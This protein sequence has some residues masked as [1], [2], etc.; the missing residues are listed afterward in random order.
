MTKKK[1]AETVGKKVTK[2]T[3]PDAGAEAATLAKNTPNALIASTPTSSAGTT[4]LKKTGKT[5]DTVLMAEGGTIPNAANFVGPPTADLKEKFS[6]QKIPLQTNFSDLIDVADCGRKAVGLSPGQLGGTGLG[7]Q[8]DAES[9]LAVIAG[10]GINVD[11][12]GV[13]V[14][15]PTILPSGMIMMFH[16]ANI[17]QGW[18]LC[19][20]ANGTPDLRDRFI[21]GGTIADSGSSNSKVTGAVTAK[22]FLANTSSVTP[23]VIVNIHD[24]VLNEEQ[25]PSH[26]HLGGIQLK[27]DGSPPDVTHYSYKVENNDRVKGTIDTDNVDWNRD[28]S[29][30]AWTSN[31]GGN[32]GHNHTNDA[33]QTPHNHSI[34]VVPPYCILAFIMKV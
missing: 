20:G 29:R 16:G 34:N 31:V 24:R 8:L 28:R 10:P 27:E 26:K 25:L 12:A 9:R 6:A 21:L 11:S 33:S 4:R 15:I 3:L 14:D 13:S 2:K 30:L 32:K 1:T 19:D 17:P 5:I 22:S 18:V 23:A 7:M